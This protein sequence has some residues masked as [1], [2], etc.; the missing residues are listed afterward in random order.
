MWHSVDIVD[1]KW[2]SYW[3]LG[4]KTV[5]AARLWDLR[6]GMMECLRVCVFARR[7]VLIGRKE[8]VRMCERAPRNT[9]YGCV[10]R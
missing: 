3:T 1:S 5:P 4:V 2:A 8:W 10:D 6:V 9:H 7:C